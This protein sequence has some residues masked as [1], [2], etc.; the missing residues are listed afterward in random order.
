M[1][2]YEYECSACGKHF[3]VFLTNHDAP[4]KKCQF[5]KS[6]K[7]K[8]L[9][10][11]CSFQLK[12]TGWYITDY[13]RKNSSDTKKKKAKSTESDSAASASDLKT[14]ADTKPSAKASTEA[15]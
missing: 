12:G 9:V 10:S 15:A 5:C 6:S 11:N 2:I 4:V 1:P 7:I 14:S 8:K 13:A 3:E